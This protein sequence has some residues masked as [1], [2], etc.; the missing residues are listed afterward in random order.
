[1]NYSYHHNFSFLRKG[2]EANPTQSR[3]T[4]QKAHN[5]EH[6]S[7]SKTKDNNNV[8]RSSNLGNMSTLNR[9]LDNLNNF[10][11]SFNSSKSKI[12]DNRDMTKI[13]K[14]VQKKITAN[15]NKPSLLGRDSNENQ[16]IS[17]LTQMFS[18]QLNHGEQTSALPS[19]HNY[20]QQQQYQ[21]QNSFHQEVSFLES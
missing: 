12:K 19:F 2:K 17:K 9:S 13:N 1:V 4:K 14:F 10:N 16:E 5:Q 20:L 18:K 6:K 15:T 8:K 21:Q 3:E 11:R 7:I